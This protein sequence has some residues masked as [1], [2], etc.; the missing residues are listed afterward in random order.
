MLD[1]I[2]TWNQALFQHRLV[3]RNIRPHGK[4][5]KRWTVTGLCSVLY[6]NWF[7]SPQNVNIKCV[8]KLTVSKITSSNKWELFCIICYILYDSST[9]VYKT[10]NCKRIQWNYDPRQINSILHPVT[11]T[12]LSLNAM[13]DTPARSAAISINGNSGYFALMGRWLVWQ[14]QFKHRNIAISLF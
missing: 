1:H 6:E 13:P 7:T 14:H 11:R 9:I 8:L 12:K 5:V 4:L 3:S 10:I 2:K